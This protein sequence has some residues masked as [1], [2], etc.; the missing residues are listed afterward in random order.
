MREVR[1]SY[2][3]QWKSTFR[4]PPVGDQI[5]E[6]SSK[7]KWNLK[8]ELNRNQVYD[9]HSPIMVSQ[10]SKSPHLSHLSAVR[11]GQIRSHTSDGRFSSTSSWCLRW[12]CHTPLSS[13]P[14]HGPR[15]ASSVRSSSRASSGRACSAKVR[16]TPGTRRWLPA[17]RSREWMEVAIILCCYIFSVWWYFFFGLFVSS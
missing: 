7:T 6:F 14:T 12:R 11:R 8:I 17:T 16:A 15:S 10:N 4:L 13:T 3:N 5:T 1:V 9:T 2:I